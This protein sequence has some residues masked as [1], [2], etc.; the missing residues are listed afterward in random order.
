[1]KVYE[2]WMKNIRDWCISRQLWWGHQIPVWYN[3]N[4]GDIYCEVTP[5]KDIENWEQDPDVLDTWFSSWLWPFSTMGWP[6]DDKDLKKFYPTDF[7][8]TAADIIFFWVA[9]MIMASIEFT[10][11]I[12]FYD[13]YFH[14]VIR[15]EK[16]RKMSKSLGNSPDVIKVM[17][18]YG[19]DAL[20][21]TIVYLAPMGTDVLFSTE[22][23][24]IG[25]NFANK[26]WNATRFL[27]MNI[28]N[29]TGSNEDY[30]HEIFDKW[31]ISRF[32]TTIKT[33][34]DALAGYRINEASKALY[35]FVWGEFCDWYIE[36]IKVKAS[37]NPKAAGK[38]FNDAINLFESTLKLLHPVMPFITEELWHGLNESRESKSISL[39]DMPDLNETVI[40]PEVEKE[41]SDIQNLVSAIRNLR[42]EINLS[43]SVK[44]EVLISCSS[45][46]SL[47]TL[48]SVKKYIISLA[49]I[50]KAEIG[51]N[52]PKPEYKSISSVVNQYQVYLKIEGIIDVEKEKERTRKEI[53]RAEGF[54]ISISKKL[55]NK[56]FVSKALPEVVEN[57]KKKQEDTKEKLEKLR[58]HYNSLA[59]F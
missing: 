20:R 49:K 10:G 45:K 1:M 48:N 54:L 42:A 21:F 31:I 7:L 32:H 2:H 36:I 11:K 58:N 34:T 15:D 39:G 24:E 40:L 12:P 52:L 17:E 23:C 14:N 26:L 33:Y 44:C 43:P 56:K 3:K 55:E 37:H 51:I 22:L 25:R 5:P 19:A 16:G 4:T 50:E 18:E 28:N 35:D 41:I 9:R 47:D 38:I 53:E 29:S 30:E 8:S 46:E 13:V 59:G 57:E 27:M 6:D